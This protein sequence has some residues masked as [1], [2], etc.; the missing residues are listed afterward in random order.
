MNIVLGPA[1]ELHRGVH[2]A[3][4][5]DPPP[6]VAFVAVPH[7][8]AF[9]FDAPGRRDPFADFSLAEVVHYD[10]RPGA[11]AG[12]HSANLPVGGE[13]GWIAD[14]DC[15]VTALRY[16]RPFI[17]G[18]PLGP[19]PHAIGADAIRKRGR[20]MIRHY[21]D[22]RC[23]AVLFW[24]AHGRR[25]AYEYVR[26]EALLLEEGL[27][28]F[29][30]KLDV[31][32]PAVAPGPPRTDGGPLT[33]LYLGRTYED[34]GGPLAADV[35]AALADVPARF[36]WVGPA[37]AEVRARLPAVEF[38]HVLPRAR[39]LE[40]LARVDV[41]FSPTEHES[42]GMG[43]VEAAAH[44]AAVVTTRGRGMEHID[45]LFVDGENALLT[46]NSFRPEA[47]LA[48]LLRQVR[49]LVENGEL[50][51]AMQ[52]ANRHLAIEGRLA[53]K[54][55]DAK[56]GEAYARFAEPVERRA[57]R[58]PHETSFPAAAMRASYRSYA[59]GGRVSVL[60]H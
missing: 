7:R 53:L 40:L 24:T 32:H 58:L 18:S 27:E 3:L 16:G 2:S 33:V 12:V 55:R 20:T 29:A 49:T 47:K 13:L 52:A 6:G 11:V 37:P 56:L 54:R 23:K 31:V 34:K 22:A 1:T 17:R 41:F 36:V 59:R 57:R 28:R 21:V 19:S 14:V 46:D 39:W 35:F 4:L 10:E 50:R 38:D 8:H 25:A 30:A 9:A 60:V 45:E 44:G 26:D 5:A 43:L 15:L 48:S 51:R 42:Y